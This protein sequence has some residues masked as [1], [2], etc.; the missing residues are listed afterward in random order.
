M[1]GGGLLWLG[2][3]HHYCALVS[4]SEHGRGRVDSFEWSSISNPATP[5][6]WRVRVWRFENG[7]SPPWH[8]DCLTG[9][10]PSC[11]PPNVVRHPGRI[12]ATRVAPMTTGTSG[13]RHRIQQCEQQ[14]PADTAHNGH[15]YVR[16]RIVPVIRPHLVPDEDSDSNRG[17]ESRPSR[18]RNHTS[19]STPPA[20][21][22]PPP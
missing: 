5:S 15:S 19:T 22:P 2:T 4:L 21:G 18:Q 17:S 13:A 6:S 8:S 14:S 16:P 1:L 3:I 12:F 10:L 20:G 11:S 7:P 9:D